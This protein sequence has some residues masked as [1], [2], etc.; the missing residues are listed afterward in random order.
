MNGK[1]RI[2]MCRARSF[3][4]HL[5]DQSVDGPGE[6]GRPGAGARRRRAKREWRALHRTLKELGATIQLVPPDD[7]PARSR[8]HRQRRGGDGPHRAAGALPPSR[9]AGRGGAFRAPLP[10]A[11]GAR[12]HRRGA[13]HAARA[14]M[15][16]G[17]G[18]C[19]WD[20][21]PRPVSG[22][23]MARARTRRRAM[24]SPIRFGIETVAL[25]LADPRFYHM[26]TA[27]AP[28]D[29]AAS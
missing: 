29:A 25:E 23:A 26:D 13:P 2:L 28:L 21:T 1:P 17:A 5:L 15:L 4:R 3:R 27:L 14:S 20:K 9:A 7:G 19:V 16:E 10:R 8:L 12:R 6:L 24:P 18:D 11:P 22:W